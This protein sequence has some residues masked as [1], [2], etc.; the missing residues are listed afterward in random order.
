MDLP[1][2]NLSYIASYLGDLDVVIEILDAK[3]K[4]LSSKQIRNK[5]IKFNPDIVGITVFVSAAINV[6]YEIAKIVKEINPYCIVVFGGRHPT[7]E[8][9]ETLKVDEIDIVVRGEG[10]LTFRDLVMGGTPEYV[11]GISYKS[12]GK[13]RHNPDRE[14]IK[15]FKNIRYPARH[16]TKKNKYN[17]L[18]MRLETVE[19][20]RGCSYQCKFCT[21]PSFSKGVWRSRPIEKIITELKMI[22]ENKKITDILFVDDN[23]TSDTKR[24]EKFCERI[25][26][27]KKNTE[28]SDFKFIAQVRADSIVKAPQ[29]VKKMAEAGFWIVFVGIESVRE[30]I[31]K[32]MRKG[33]I[34]NKVL[35]ALQILHNNNIIIIGNVIIGFDLNATEEDIRK[36]I[37]FL[38]KVEVDVITFTLL[39]PFPGTQIQKELEKNNLIVS[40]DWSKY[41]LIDPVIKTYQLSPKKLQ[42]LLFYCFKE[43]N[44][45]RNWNGLALRIFRTRKISI[46]LN[47][48]RIFSLF[49]SFI[50]VRI[51]IKKFFMG[52]KLK[53][54]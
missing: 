23:F 27:C 31:L 5:I 3:V 33:F 4:K 2:I 10:E 7:A 41:T 46:I 15:D 36:N 30:E 14:L 9:E 50:K 32:N 1:P 43:H 42:E 29:M 13:I 38:K 17:M 22:S 12:N 26:E 8:P 20:S 18:T 35:K 16:L 53:G 51:L 21:T 48:I 24:I 49:N 25:I 28:I 54:S 19:T 6:C 11:K 37:K 47:P 40:K 44:Y 52:I 34:F 45:L 39:T